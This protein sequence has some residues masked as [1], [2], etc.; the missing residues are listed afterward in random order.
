MLNLAYNAI[1]A[2]DNLAGLDLY[3]LN[4]EGNRVE[5]IS[6]LREQVNLLHLNLARNRIRK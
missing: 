5:H 6:G 4:L 2:V 1:E 3:D